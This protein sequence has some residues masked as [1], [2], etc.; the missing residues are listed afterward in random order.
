MVNRFLRYFKSL[1]SYIVLFYMSIWWHIG[2]DL[3]IINTNRDLFNNIN[4]RKWLFVKL[5][6]LASKIKQLFDFLF[7]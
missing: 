5:F 6:F 2:L 3:F 7:L 1:T 4:G